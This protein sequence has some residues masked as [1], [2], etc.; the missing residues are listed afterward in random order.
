MSFP[1]KLCFAGHTHAL[2]VFSL[3]Q[4]DK[5]GRGK[6]GVES[7]ELDFRRRYIIVPGSI[8]Q[9][10]DSISDRAKYGIWD[11]EAKT[12][13]IRDVAYDVETTIRLL[14]ELHFPLS[15]IQRLKWPKKQ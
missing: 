8:G 4:A 5:T 12:I 6:L 1:E 7:I 10:R 9:P 11:Q 2:D 15:N 13:E 14:Q 3:D